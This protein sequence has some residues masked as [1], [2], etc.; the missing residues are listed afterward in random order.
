MYLTL[1]WLM[2][3][4]GY[5]ASTAS[6]LVCESMHPLHNI[7]IRYEPHENVEI[8]ACAQRQLDLSS[9]GGSFAVQIFRWSRT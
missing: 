3:P 1:T 5:P 4:V 2:A 9:S 6:A 8:E 7:C